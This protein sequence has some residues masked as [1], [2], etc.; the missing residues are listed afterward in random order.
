MSL[1]WDKSGSRAAALQKEKQ[2]PR[3][4]DLLGIQVFGGV[5][6]EEQKN[7]L[8]CPRPHEMEAG[9]SRPIAC[10]RNKAFCISAI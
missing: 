9:R 7:L 8:W 6:N 3:C 4:E 1:C 10:D 5:G 2:I